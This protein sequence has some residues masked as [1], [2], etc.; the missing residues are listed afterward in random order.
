M[1]VKRLTMNGVRGFDGRRRVD[2]DFTRPDGSYAGWTVLA[3][4][5]GSGKTTLLRAIAL[6]WA[7]E[8]L[9]VQLEDR[10]E[11]WLSER[12][13]AGRIGLEILSDPL[14]DAGSHEPLVG[15]LTVRWWMGPRSAG[16]TLFEPEVVKR[17]EFA[18]VRFE[19]DSD[20]FEEILWSGADIPGWFVAAYGPFR[21][22]SGGDAGAR[23][24]VDM[25]RMPDFSAKQNAVQTLFGEKFS[26]SETA[27]WLLRLHTERLEGRRDAVELVEMII[28]LLQDGLLPDGHRVSKLD[29]GGLW[30]ENEETGRT[31]PLA[32][33]SDGYRTVVVLVLDIIRSMFE[34][35]PYLG[36]RA[37][38]YENEV[39]TLRHPG[40]VLIDE[41]DAHLHVSWQ[42]RIGEWLKRHFPQV[43]FIVT[44]HSP[45]ICQAAD[46]NGLIRLPGPSE[47]SAPCVVEDEL[48]RRV[49]HGTGDDAVISDLF[50]LDTPFSPESQELRREL[51]GLEKALVLGR[52]TDADKQ[53]L[54]D[55]KV[56]LASSPVTRVDEISARLLGD[57]DAR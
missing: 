51:V 44:T 55:L 48:Y 8:R 27:S 42:Q 25:D 46:A 31:A 22:L 38:V 54:R 24:T 49:V 35:Y 53:R 20:L 23:R 18:R 21:R 9:G 30:I 57:G 16:P 36:E 19:A 37:L 33:M 2:L 50:G 7:G 17:L 6:A 11:G 32:R 41:V 39:P 10:L 47:E 34:A 45:Y 4:R 56:R 43:Q 40:V 12:A 13:D 1:Y 29:G 28:A 52:A 15:R 3:G 5:N 26:L 14:W